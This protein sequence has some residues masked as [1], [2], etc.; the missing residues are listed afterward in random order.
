MCIILTKKNCQRLNEIIQVN[1][2]KLFRNVL[3][4]DKKNSIN[5]DIESGFEQVG[6]SKSKSLKKTFFLKNKTNIL[7]TVKFQSIKKESLA[8][9]S[10]HRWSIHI[11]V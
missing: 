8:P 9:S 1:S 11:M 2:S 6:T 5:K 7:Q 3:P 4:V 10:K